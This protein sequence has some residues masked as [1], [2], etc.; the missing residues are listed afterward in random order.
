MKHPF[1]ILFHDCHWLLAVLHLGVS[2]TLLWCLST[3]SC[4]G[5]ARY[6]YTLVLLGGLE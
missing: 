4:A 6:L 1:Y 2:G 3:W 5:L